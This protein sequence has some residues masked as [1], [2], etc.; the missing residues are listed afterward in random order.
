MK[1]LMSLF[2]CLG[3]AGCSTVSVNVHT[4]GNKVIMTSIDKTGEMTMTVFK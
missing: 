4:E 3:V 1:F 2:L